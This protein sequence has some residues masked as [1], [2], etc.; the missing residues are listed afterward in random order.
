M[1]E[2]LSCGGRY[3]NTLPD[4]TR[5]FHVCPPVPALKV[6]RQGAEVLV[7]LHLVRRTDIVRVSRDGKELAVPHADVAPLDLVLEATDMPRPNAR[8]ENLDREKERRALGDNAERRRDVSD[9]DLMIA[10]GAGVK[11]L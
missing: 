8:N 5:Y 9:E 4:G 11:Q 3:E 6:S 10:A 7:A 1:V 2:C